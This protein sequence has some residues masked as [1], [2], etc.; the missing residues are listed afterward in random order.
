MLEVFSTVY[1]WAPT[2]CYSIK[3]ANEL[4]TPSLLK[5]MKGTQVLV[6]DYFP[7]IPEEEQKSSRRNVVIY[8]SPSNR[9]PEAQTV[10][11]NFGPDAAILIS[12]EL[13][14]IEP[15]GYQYMLLHEWRHIRCSHGLCSALLGAAASTTTAYIF[16]Y[17]QPYLPPWAQAV[18]CS[19]P[20]AAGYF[21]QHSFMS[22]AE[23][24]AN[25]DASRNVTVAQLQGAERM[26]M[27]KI[28]VNIG[29]HKQYPNHFTANGN[30]TN[31]YI[32]LTTRLEN[33]QEE[34]LNRDQAVSKKLD[35]GDR[36]VERLMEYYRNI[37]EKSLGIDKVKAHRD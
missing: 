12:E 9:T 14:D 17:L 1:T 27:A 13:A 31:D 10:G 4:F 19:I 24:D 15:D 35:M 28:R 33:I 22:I 37:T 8:P 25:A 23:L 30:K 11:T 26:T 29:Y 21:A 34:L 16:P 7:E 18:A 5:S 32:P 20:A 3:I 6:K 36:R 2:V